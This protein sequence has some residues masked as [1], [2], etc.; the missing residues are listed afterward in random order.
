MRSG[1]LGTAC[2]RNDEIDESRVQCLIQSQFI[3]SPE[4]RTSSALAYLSTVQHRPFS[5]QNR[6]GFF[7]HR[8]PCC[9]H[10]LRLSE[11]RTDGH[12]QSVHSGQNLNAAQGNEACF[13]N[14]RLAF[15]QI[16]EVG[17]G[18]TVCV[19]NTSPLELMAS[20]RV[21]FNV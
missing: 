20:R 13:R 5:S 16:M 10:M 3:S 21:E 19:R 9:R 15:A 7:H 17:G 6:R 12:S 2:E 11:S 14:L 1:L 8:C 4:L 18:T